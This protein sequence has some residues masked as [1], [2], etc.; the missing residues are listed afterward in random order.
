M[1]VLFKTKGTDSDMPERHIERDRDREGGSDAQTKQKSHGNDGTTIN[2]VDNT[3]TT[4]K[5][6]KNTTMLRNRTKRRAILG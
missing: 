6:T 1:K 4:S 3:R 2:N 5:E